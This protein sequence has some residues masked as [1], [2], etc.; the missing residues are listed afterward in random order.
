MLRI[1]TLTVSVALSTAALAQ[2]SSTQEW[3]CRDSG[4]VPCSGEECDGSNVAEKRKM[5]V[6]LTSEGKVS[7]CNVIDCW[8]GTGDI[9][10]ND[11][12]FSV[13]LRNVLWTWDS[14]VDTLAERVSVTLDPEWGLA[15][16][17]IDD[18]KLAY[19]CELQE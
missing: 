6:L 11:A 1:A 4:I 15:A 12:L 19:F 14:R 8:S 7:F 9:T 5:S 10:M 13:S 16:V 2:E 3:L 17:V 18:E